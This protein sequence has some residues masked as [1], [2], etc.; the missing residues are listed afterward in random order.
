VASR[1]RIG[2]QLAGH[3]NVVTSL[4]FS[5]DGKTMA[6]GSYDHTVILWDLKNRLRIGEP[7][8]C[9][10][11]YITKVAFSPDGKTL[12]TGGWNGPVM[13]WDVDLTSWITKA[14]RIAN[15]ALTPEERHRYLGTE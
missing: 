13:L 9:D 11:T 14:K 2:E 10:S 1:Q 5:P 6:S 3:H 7:L 4:A 15:R 8:A 12:A